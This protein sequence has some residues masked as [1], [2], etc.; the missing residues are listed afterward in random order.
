MLTDNAETTPTVRENVFSCDDHNACP[1]Q[2]PK[3]GVAFSNL[4]SQACGVKEHLF[5]TIEAESTLSLSNSEKI[6]A[7]CFR[8]NLRKRRREQGYVFENPLPA[9]QFAKLGNNC[10]VCKR[11]IRMAQVA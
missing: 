9:H 11:G 10:F 6:A 8:M 1:F 3:D 4:P 5:P 2:L 7:R